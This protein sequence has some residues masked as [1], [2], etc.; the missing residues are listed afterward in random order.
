MVCE[1]FLYL[2]VSTVGTW[3]I[4]Y[5]D[6]RCVVLHMHKLFCYMMNDLRINIETHVQ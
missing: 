1:I 6:I 3:S 2:Y 5:I 4:V